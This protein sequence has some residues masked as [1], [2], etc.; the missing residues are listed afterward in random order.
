MNDARKA[1]YLLDQGRALLFVHA[2]RPGDQ[3]I[4]I[5]DGFAPPAQR[6]RRRDFLYA[7]DLLQVLGQLFRRAV[8][9]IQQKPPRDAAIILD[10]FEDFLLALL[11]H[12]RQFAQLAVARQLFHS[13]EIA[14]LEGAPQQRDGLRSEPLNLQQLQHAGPVLLQQFLVLRKLAF[15]AQL[16]NIRRHSFTDTGNPQQLFRFIQQFRNLLRMSL[17]GFRRPTIGT[18]AE[19]VVAIDLHQVG[20]FVE[21][22]S[23]SLI[24]QAQ[25]PV[26]NCSLCGQVM[27]SRTASPEEYSTVRKRLSMSTKGSPRVSA[28][29]RPCLN[30]SL[31]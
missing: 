7:F 18:D 13:G 17:Q 21:D 11:A 9:F 8:G 31:S 15:A 6:S 27:F 12:A 30:P 25:I 26:R 16:L 4:Q 3:H 5:A 19:R 2:A 24:V 23:D 1:Q 14:Y 28:S 20:G 22:V 29:K 10:C